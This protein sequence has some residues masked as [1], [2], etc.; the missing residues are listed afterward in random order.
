MHLLGID[1]ETTGLE[2]GCNFIIEIGA[3]IWDTETKKPVRMV[4]EFVTLPPGVEVPKEITELTGITTNDCNVHGLSLGGVINKIEELTLFVTQEEYKVAYNA[5]FEEKF[6]H[7]LNI[8]DF[9]ILPWIDPQYD[10]PF[11]S[12]IKTRKLDYL[13]YEHGFRNQFK[14]RALFDVLA[15]FEIMSQYDLA[16]IIKRSKSP[17]TR[18]GALVSYED[19]LLAKKEG[20]W[21]DGDIR[22]WIKDVK[23]MDIDYLSKNLPFGIINLSQPAYD[24][25]DD[26]LF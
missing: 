16:T 8:R 12:N 3:A 4:S 13:C 21:W 14:H 2:P 1:I 22:Y 5:E 18:I 15:M 7:D 10:I 26:S 11:P 9:N 17:K 23:E 6:L 19:R 24:E 20:F 25:E